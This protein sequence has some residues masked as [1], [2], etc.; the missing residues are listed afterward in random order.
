MG[1]IHNGNTY[2]DLNGK[3][4]QNSRCYSGQY[5]NDPENNSQNGSK[6]NS[7]RKNENG[8]IKPGVGK[9][10]YYLTNIKNDT[11]SNKS[12]EEI[13]ESQ[14]GEIKKSQENDKDA[15][16]S[17]EIKTNKSS[18]NQSKVNNGYVKGN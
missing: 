3:S 10:T 8:T 12:Q 11:D 14:N 4:S 5:Q 2:H 1:D 6:Q 18:I 7:V 9:G 17:Q 15:H 13:S 16:N